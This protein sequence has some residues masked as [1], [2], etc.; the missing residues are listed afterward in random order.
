MVWLLSLNS[1]G[2]AFTGKR[3]AQPWGRRVVGVSVWSFMVAVGL[4][5]SY[6]ELY[7]HSK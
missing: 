1:F 6:T 3:Q 4:T 7:V 5:T 2:I